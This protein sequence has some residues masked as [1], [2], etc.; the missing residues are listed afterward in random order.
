MAT[1]E[2]WEQL[3][4][5]ADVDCV[6][7]SCVLELRDRVEALEAAQNLRQQDEDVEQVAADLLIPTDE[8]LAAC[9]ANAAK[10]AI[11]ERKDYDK[12]LT[13]AD[14]TKVQS[15]ALYDLGRKHG[16][17][18]NSKP[19]PN[20]RQ[21]RSSLVKK[22]EQAMEDLWVVGEIE[23]SWDAQA[24]AAIR[25][26]AAWLDSNEG[27]PELATPKESDGW[28]MAADVLLKEADR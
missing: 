16:A 5:Y 19:T 20:D 25:E 15:R 7:E 22:V 18:A 1:Q 8:E 12:A 10:V 11:L 21:I 2:Q 6:P 24:R 27:L 4:N 9:S 26:V 17:A 14:I 23:G 13:S 3:A 28:Q